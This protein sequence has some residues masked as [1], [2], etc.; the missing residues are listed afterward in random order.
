M[1]KYFIIGIV[2]S[3]GLIFSCINHSKVEKIDN[4]WNHLINARGADD[5]KAALI[6]FRKYL[7]SNNIS[8]E[9]F[10]NV[11]GE[12]KKIED[13]K[14]TDSMYSI[15]MQFQKIGDSTTILKENWRPKNN[16]DVFLFLGE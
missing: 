5:E 10:R 9:L 2:I 8:Y 13:T 15:S 12:L 7:Q 6:S 11:E 4:Y 16:E 3:S 14:E 1:K